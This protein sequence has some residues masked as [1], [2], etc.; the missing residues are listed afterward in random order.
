LP[1]ATPA[2][3]PTPP[4]ATLLLG[5]RPSLLLSSPAPMAGPEPTSPEFVSSARPV[6]S[7]LG[8]S[9][10]SSRGSSGSPPSPPPQLTS[11]PEQEHAHRPVQERLVWQR[12]KL[13]RKAAWRRRK[14][15]QQL[16]AQAGPSRLAQAP[17][18][19]G[20]C[21]R[22]LEKGH[23]K[24]GCTNDEVC[25]RCTEEG[26]SS[27]GCKRPRSPASEDE[28]RRQA[29]AAVALRRRAARGRAPDPDSS[30][31]TR[32]QEGLASRTPAPQPAAVR[33]EHLSPLSTPPAPPRATSASG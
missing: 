31:M 5:R 16:R 29:L 24:L 13:S 27:G 9:S 18:M 14:R 19:Q 32:L 28:L 22:Y 30:A 7:G 3:A 26:H 20:V 6:V 4:T 15:E 10:G 21:F 1:A 2:T 23:P 17:E 25:I 11:A 33:Q 8:L 12:P